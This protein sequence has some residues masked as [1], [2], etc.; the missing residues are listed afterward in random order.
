MHS[1]TMILFDVDGTLV[2]SNK[3]DS[4]SFAE[5]YQEIYGEAF[6]TIDWRS[7]PHVTDHTIF[8]T[9]IEER[10]GRAVRAGEI[11]TFQDHFVNL[12]AQ[13]RVGMPEEFKMV[14]GARSAIKRLQEDGYVVG[15]GTGGWERPARL[16][17]EHVAIATTNLVISAAD[18]KVTR[19]DILQDAIDQAEVKYGALERVVYIGDAIWDVKTTRNMNL[20]FVGL[21]LQGDFEALADAGANVVIKNYQ[22]YTA[23]LNALEIARPPQEIKK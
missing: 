6:P 20:D 15:I 19:E 17:L 4:I 13:K 1:K 23:F 7:Y 3:I 18:N 21:R 8:G 10:F 16:K 14:P 12:L 2:Y 5:T 11:E 9:V 22:D